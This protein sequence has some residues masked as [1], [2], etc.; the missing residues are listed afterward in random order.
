LTILNAVLTRESALLCAD[1]EAMVPVPGGA[2]A[3]HTTKLLP[4]PHM[5]VV[6][7]A[8]GSLA[9][10]SILFQALL[11][12]EVRSIDELPNFMPQTLS[13][14]GRTLD[15]G[16]AQQGLAFERREEV[17]IVGWSP[18]RR[19]MVGYCWKC[20]EPG[21]DFT[22]HEVDEVFAAPWDTSLVAPPATANVDLM[23]RFAERQ[24]QFVLKQHPGT[25]AGGELIFA[26]LTQESV[27]F[28]AVHRFAEPERQTGG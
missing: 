23:V 19:Q 18:S 10:A 17:L 13:V 7:G 25:A 11:F 8:R 5:R 3:I 4:L 22:R 27:S 6:F 28:R 9:F 21:A 26:H 14:V 24:R 15:A 2:R 12:A 16:L 1:T 20:P